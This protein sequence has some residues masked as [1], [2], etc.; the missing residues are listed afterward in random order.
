MSK[1]FISMLNMSL[2]AS[3]IILFVM[4]IRIPLKK[5]PKAISYALWSVVAFRLIIPFSLESI[6]SL[7]PRN[8]NAN[9]IPQDI[10]YQQSPQ[11]NSGIKIVDSFINQSL[12]APIIGAS[13]N[14]LQI[15]AEI[16]A[17]IWILGMIILFIYS[18]TSI[19]LLKKQLKSA[20]LIENNIF[21]AGNLKTPF[22]LGLIRPK[23]YLPEGINYEERSYILLHEQTHIHRK[24]HIIKIF[25][26]LIL[27]IHWF[28]PL[29]W[30][31]FILMSRDMELSCDE[32]VLKEKN[33]NIKKAYASSLLSLASGRH[34]LHASPLAFGEGNVKGRIKNVMNYKKP[35]FW[36]ILIAM[37][38]AIVVSIGLI[39]NPINDTKL[40]DASDIYQVSEKWAEALK[41]RDGKIR[42][43][44]MAPESKADYYNSLVEI[45]G[46]VEYPWVIGWSSPYVESYDI[47][48]SR[49]SA[50]ITYITKT[51]S[52]SEEYVY[53]EQ[54]FFTNIEGKNYVSK[55]YE[56]DISKSNIE[57]T[58]N[59]GDS[60]KFTKEEIGEA[61]ELVKN[62]FD[63]P[64]STLTKIW[65]KEEE[66]D[67][68][69]KLYLDYGRGSVNGA[70]SENVIVLLSNF[71]VDDSGEDSSLNPNST[72][73]NFQWILIRSDD[74]SDWEIDDR[75][76]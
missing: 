58:I 65:Y 21:K 43:D 40:S 41:N 4:L 54:L 73:E 68:F 19:L 28:N 69:S 46:E 25:A 1:L 36:V 70:E 52:E 49:E 37:I 50:V 26:F 56:F 10:I 38:L 16:G 3:Y 18:V 55:Y 9:P 15:Y 17:Y 64:A 63:F 47:E 53:Q 8:M 35:K 71:D 59:I 75:G 66:S 76:Y 34:I 31:A 27:S 44:L 48:I 24:D 7:I 45:N 61:I 30:I 62:D 74:N 12:S 67:K 20:E 5:A 42:Y 32:R 60:I 11:I 14:P 2:M 6:F 72:Y 33:E 51:Q 23:I 22:V 29:V 57:P 39:V 13:T